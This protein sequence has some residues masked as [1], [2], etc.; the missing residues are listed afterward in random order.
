[1]SSTSP[2]NR[3]GKIKTLITSFIVAIILWVVASYTDG[4]DVTVSLNNIPIRF[5]GLDAIQDNSLTIINQNKLPS[6]S[7]SVRGT[8]KNLVNAINNITARVDVSALENAGIY[9]LT[10]EIVIADSNVTLEKKKFDDVQIELDNVEEKEIPLVLRQTGVNKNYLIQSEPEYDSIVISGAVSEVEQVSKGFI[11]V[12]ISNFTQDNTS[13]CSVI[14]TDASNTN[15]DKL[16]TV[17]IMGHSKVS[18]HNTVYM[19]ENLNI[20]ATVSDDI[21]KNYKIT[22]KSISPQSVTAGLLDTASNISNLEVCFDNTIAYGS[23]V[24]EYVLDVKIPDGVYVPAASRKIKVK[25]DVEPKK[26][27]VLTIPVTYSN[28]PQGLH[29]YG[30]A[31]ININVKGPENKLTADNIKAVVDLGGCSAGNYTMPITLTSD[32]ELTLPEFVTIAVT[33]S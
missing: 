3:Y 14:F 12:D 23:G 7:I 30:D 32:S 9:S 28:V 19:S 8:R 11:T 22:V 21:S 15:L 2:T 13:L 1:M 10:P 25:A 6:L 33:L 31:N 4:M 27:K 26:E 29:V 5:V 16:E 24:G 18:V 20:A 17:Q